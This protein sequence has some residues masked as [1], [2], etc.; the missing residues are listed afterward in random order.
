MNQAG[1]PIPFLR[2][3]ALILRART[4]Q[5]V[6]ASIVSKLGLPDPL[7]APVTTKITVLQEAMFV[8]EASAAAKHL[9][10]GFECGLSFGTASALPDYIAQH[11]PTL[12]EGFDLAMSYMQTTLPG[13]NFALKEQG[14][15]VSVRL[16]VKDPNLSGYP[17]YHEAL[18]ASLVAQI[19]AFTDRAFYP[20]R[21]SFVHARAPVSQKISSRFGCNVAF[22]AEQTELL[23]SPT[24][25][26]APMIAR[27]DIL[28]GYL[29]S[30]ADKELEDL[31]RPEPKLAEQVE[32]LLEAG[33]PA[34][35]PTLDDVARSLALS[36]R[37]LSRR[38]REA[39][40]SFQ[41]LR[42]LVR[43]RLAARELR[44]SDMPI[45]E[46]AWRLGY[47]TQTSF[48]TAFRRETGQS[49]SAYRQNARNV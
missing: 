6:L 14:N 20:D 41:V 4:S 25:L 9:D 7:V 19:R 27:D 8:E 30:Q 21:L 16:V 48:S 46:I 31:K 23:A 33:F 37:T 22:S 36:R 5:D 11:A 17:R 2:H 49:P 44:D 1:P 42:N 47:S 29:I 45:G 28:N 35:L 13:V 32:L 34:H 18:F 24:I 10:F 43:M 12:R 39:D 40:L 38:L 3:C 26:D 15:T